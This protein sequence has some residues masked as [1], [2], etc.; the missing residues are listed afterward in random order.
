MV[1]GVVNKLGINWGISITG[2]VGFGGGSDIKFVGLVYIGIVKYK[3]KVE[4]FEYCFSYLCDCD[5]IRR[6][7]VFLVFD[8]LRRRLC[9]FK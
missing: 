7:S 5:W 2:I 3:D 4:S 9:L 8:I 1:S 6:V